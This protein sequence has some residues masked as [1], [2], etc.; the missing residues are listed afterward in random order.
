MGLLALQA[1][2]ENVIPTLTFHIA[3]VMLGI[4]KSRLEAQ[5]EQGNQETDGVS[6]LLR[7]LSLH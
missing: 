5:T 6:N 7:F 3:M 1:G 2:G 4:E